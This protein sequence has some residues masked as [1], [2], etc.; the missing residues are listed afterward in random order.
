MERMI[1]WICVKEICF[2]RNWFEV[3][4]RLTFHSSESNLMK[5]GPSLVS[6]KSSRAQML[7]CLNH[8]FLAFSCLENILQRHIPLHS[9]PKSK[10][11]ILPPLKIHQ[12]PASPDSSLSE[13]SSPSLDLV[14][15]LTLLILVGS[16]RHAGGIIRWNLRIRRSP[17]VRRG[18]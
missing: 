2:A 11:I 4:C 8:L 5:A 16:S 9:L 17:R 12:S 10:P 15:N 18:R 3:T 14:F 6:V 1:G 13:H 7:L